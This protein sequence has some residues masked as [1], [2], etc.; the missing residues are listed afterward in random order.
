MNTDTWRVQIVTNFKL[1]VNSKWELSREKIDNARKLSVLKLLSANSKRVNDRRFL[2]SKENI[3]AYSVYY[4]WKNLLCVIKGGRTK[5]SNKVTSVMIIQGSIREF[6]QWRRWSRGQRRKVKMN[7]YLI[8][9]FRN[10]LH[11]GSVRWFLPEL[12]QAKYVTTAFN[13]RRIKTNYPSSCAFSKIRRALSFQ[14]VVVQRLQAK[15]CQTVT[16]L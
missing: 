2:A 10:S 7:F 6:K 15:K 9:E 1:W 11:A 5:L 14:V 4:S 16:D 3:S 8:F 12:A 13:S